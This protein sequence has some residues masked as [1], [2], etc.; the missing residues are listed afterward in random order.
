MNRV[1]FEL[2]DELMFMLDEYV[3]YLRKQNKSYR[4]SKADVCR[5]MI[6][7]VHRAIPKDGLVKEAPVPIPEALL[8]PAEKFM[9]DLKERTA[10]T[11]GQASS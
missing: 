6:E 11:N 2:C 1:T 4:L 7:E 9:K 3:T 5:R 10:K 8:T